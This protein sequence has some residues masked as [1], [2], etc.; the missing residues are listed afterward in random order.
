[1]RQEFNL[2]DEV[3]YRA[4]KHLRKINDQSKESMA[5]LNDAGEGTRES[6]WR[7]NLKN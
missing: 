1:M 6:S 5:N 2:D 4:V 3:K 7:K